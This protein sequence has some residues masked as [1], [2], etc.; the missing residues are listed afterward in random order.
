MGLRQRSLDQHLRQRYG[1]ELIAPHKAAWRPQLR[2]A[3][4]Y[5]VSPPLED[6][7]LFAWLHNFRRL[8]IR[9]EYYPNNFLGM[10]QSLAVILLRYL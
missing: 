7:T 5:A 2:T 6:G 8:V 3:G 1:V 10:V 4:A 9:W